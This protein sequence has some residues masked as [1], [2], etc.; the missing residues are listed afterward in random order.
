[1]KTL[2][3]FVLIAALS[4]FTSCAENKIEI[5]S[6]PDESS[7]EKQAQSVSL[8]D[9]QGAWWADDDPKAPTAAF[10]ISGEDVWLDRLGDYSPCRIEGDFLIFDLTRK[11]EL[12]KNKII[13]LEGNKL[14]IQWQSGEFKTL[15]RATN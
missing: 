7:A 5:V 10:A 3:H 1:M 4:A 12:I 11:N 15:T 9:L 6:Q 8:D 13:S 14:V 2:R